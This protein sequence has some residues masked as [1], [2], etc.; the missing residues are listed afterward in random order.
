VELELALEQELLESSRELATEDAAEN[1]D[2]QKEAWSR[3]DPSGAIEREA[4]GRDDAVDMRVM[5][6]VESPVCRT[7]SSPMSAPRCFGSR[8][9]SSS[10]AALVQKSRS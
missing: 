3:S 7:S 9:T 8:A 6:K 5:L 4:A 10:V 1:A 2:R